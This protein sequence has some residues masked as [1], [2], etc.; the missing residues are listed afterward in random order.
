MKRIDTFDWHKEW[1]NR[2]ALFYCFTVC[3][4]IGLHPRRCARFIQLSSVVPA[5]PM[6]SLTNVDYSLKITFLYQSE[7]T[8]SVHLL[9]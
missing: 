7:V 8:L 3:F 2:N 5:G 1:F 4:Y 9:F 6:F